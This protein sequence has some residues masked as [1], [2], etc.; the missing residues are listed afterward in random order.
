MWGRDPALHVQEITPSEPAPGWVVLPRV[1]Q[2]HR[3]RVARFPEY[4][5]PAQAACP[6][7]RLDLHRPV[8]N[9][10]VGLVLV[11]PRVPVHGR[12]QDFLAVAVAVAALLVAPPVARPVAHP[13]VVV[14][15]LAAVVE[16]QVA[17]VVVVV[18]V[19]VA[20]PRVP[21]GDPAADR[22]GVASRSGRSGKSLTTC[23]HRPLVDFGCRRE[24]GSR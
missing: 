2:V 12:P 6:L 8:V 4:L 17:P 1:K 13:V 18:P 14:D 16:A 24:M 15:L 10:P 3:Q 23:R 20:V 19:V 11:D 22:H 21:S 9:D 5:V 7:G